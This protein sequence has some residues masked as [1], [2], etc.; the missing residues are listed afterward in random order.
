MQPANK[1]SLFSHFADLEDPRIDRTKKHLLLDIIALA[2]CA[3]IGGAEGWEEIEDFG[4]DKH[5]WLRKFLRL[6][7]GIPSHDTISRVFRRLKPEAFQE[8]F[9]SWVQTLH[10]ELGWK[11]VAIDGKTVRRSFDRVTAKNA[12]HLVSAWSVENHLTLG[13]QAVDGKS[14]EITAIPELLRLLEL[15]GAIVTIDAMGCQKNIAQDIVDGGGN[16][17]LA[18]KGNQPTLHTALQDHFLELHETEFADAEV[19]RWVTR[20]TAHGREVERHYYITPVPESLR[21]Q[22]EWA[23]LRS[24]GQVITFTEEN[25]KSSDDVRYYINSIPPRVKLF[26]S[27]TRGHWGI[28]N[29]LHWV[30]DVTF[31]EDRSR[32]RKDHGGENFSLLRRIALSLIKQDTTK[33]SVRRKRKRAGWNNQ[34]LLNILTTKT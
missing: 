26:A 14:N 12:L 4:K 9:L 20:E 10:Q 31:D 5:D 28:E 8:C 23:N 11:H 3:V 6:P 29:S 30:L 33:Q 34:N 25:G 17:V 13:Q 22:S 21:G 1:L 19:R 32:I 18:V 27:A 15:E 16:Y 24:V 7:N 2:I